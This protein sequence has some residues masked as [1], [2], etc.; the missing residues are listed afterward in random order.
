MKRSF[1]E[2]RGGSGGGSSGA[3]TE[4]SAS[5]HVHLR[6]LFVFMFDYALSDDGQITIFEMQQFSTSV[7]SEL[8]NFSPTRLSK[9]SRQLLDR[10][11]IREDFLE[12]QMFDFG[13]V[14]QRVEMQK[15]GL[16]EYQPEFTYFNSDKIDKDSD[17]N[18]I[19][20]AFLLKNPDSKEFVFK[21]NLSSSGRGNIFLTREEIESALKERKIHEILAPLKSEYEYGDRANISL[22]TADRNPKCQSLRSF[23][24]FDPQTKEF[25]CFTSGIYFHEEGG[26]D[27]HTHKAEG[28]EYSYS[29]GYFYGFKADR[30]VEMRQL[31]EEETKANPNEYV[32]K[33]FNKIC[34][35]LFG[36]ETRLLATINAPRIFHLAPGRK[37]HSLRS[38]YTDALSF[39]LLNILEANKSFHKSFSDILGLEEEAKFVQILAEDKKRIAEF[40]A[41]KAKGK[42]GGFE[43]D[44][45]QELQKFSGEILK[46]Y[47]PI[48]KIPGV[49]DLLS[50]VSFISG[51]NKDQNFYYLKKLLGFTLFGQKFEAENGVIYQKNFDKFMMMPIDGEAV[52]KLDE[53]G[54]TPEKS[55]SKTS[56]EAVLHSAGKVA[57]AP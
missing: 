13:K 11:N 28:R 14:D 39:F 6:R 42:P 53:I 9:T 56:G 3:A 40:K 48:F 10:L 17:L 1:D 18:E 55:A 12:Y 15:A 19:I 45:K 21:K 24:A 25:S 20:A 34:N 32:S 52:K 30:T 57:T 8:A 31:S 37:H 54:R 50:K 38:Q 22:E 2:H 43:K 27:S 36:D 46:K 29:D 7:H 51:G 4:A 47:L 49:R 5:S 35:A 23:V 33:A 26:V 44:D 16:D 41:E